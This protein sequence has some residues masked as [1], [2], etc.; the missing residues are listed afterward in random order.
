MAKL[1]EEG[2]RVTSVVLKL[3]QVLIK[4]QVV[5]KMLHNFLNRNGKQVMFHISHHLHG[6]KPASYLK[7]IIFSRRRADVCAVMNI[8]AHDHCCVEK[9]VIGKR[10]TINRT[11]VNSVSR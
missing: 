5:E 10:L 11:L 8:K 9:T 4:I 6:V 3:F 1:A 2:S 7:A